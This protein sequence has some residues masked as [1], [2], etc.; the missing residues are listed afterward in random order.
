ML[1]AEIRALLDHPGFQEG[2]HWQRRR[3]AGGQA[4]FREG[5]AGTEL[6][7]ILAGS[8]RV[9]GEVALEARRRIQSGLCDLPTGALFG[10]VALFDQGPRS[11]TVVAVEDTE[12]AV[13]DGE[14]LLRFFEANPEIGYNIL[15]K[16]ITVMVGRIR[17]TNKKLVSLFAWGLK[18][19]QIE[20]HL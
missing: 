5:E 20:Q 11:A 16:L 6:F 3:V 12:L 19:H 14:R 8:V 13:I 2:S 17:A 1:E 4:V 18:A 7:L 10:E 9:V 15:K